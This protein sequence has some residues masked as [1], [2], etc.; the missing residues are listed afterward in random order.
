MP[1]GPELKYLQELLKSKILNKKLYKIESINTK[2]IRIKDNNNYIRKIGRK[3]KLLWLKINKNKYIHI[4]L[5]LTGWLSFE[6]TD[7]PK[8]ILHFNKFKLYFDSKRKFSNIKIVNEKKHKK[9]LDSLGIDIFSDE[10]TYEKF[11]ELVTK[12]D[13]KLVTFLLD[14]KN[15]AGIGNYI[16]SESLYI[17]KINPHIKTGDLNNKQIKKLYNAIRFVA[18]S[19][20]ID[21]LKTDKLKIPKNIKK[22]KPKKLSNPYYFKVYGQKIDLKGNKITREEINGRGTYYVKKIQK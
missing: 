11:Y 8:Y 2:S 4:H 3:G 12:G 14:Q 1:E 6:E 13:R 10:F 20:L 18:Y 19:I 5:M 7:N 9:A 17:A 16:K 15:I 22:N 21:H